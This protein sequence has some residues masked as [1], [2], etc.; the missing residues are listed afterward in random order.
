M[1][2]S[3][4]WFCP[5]LP[6]RWYEEYID[7]DSNKSYVNSSPEQLGLLSKN[8]QK[9]KHSK[10]S[11]K[12]QNKFYKRNKCNVTK[13]EHL[14][15]PP[16]PPTTACRGCFGS[17]TEPGVKLHLLFLRH[18]SSVCYHGF[19][20]RSLTPRG[21]ILNFSVQWGLLLCIFVDVYKSP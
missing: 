1:V 11:F 18:L 5:L 17:V 4:L 19:T 2:C 12:Q 14:L 7:I 8:K 9:K 21:N 20:L 13:K 6:P 10:L 3:A 16:P 15:P